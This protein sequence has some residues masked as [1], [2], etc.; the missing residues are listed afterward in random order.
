MMQPTDPGKCDDVPDF[1]A[2]DRPLFWSVLFEPKV[3][4][5][6]VVV[7]NVRPDHAPKLVLVDRDHMVQ[8]ISS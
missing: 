8:T 2:F 7:V 6:R 5:I 4:P 1:S 3:G